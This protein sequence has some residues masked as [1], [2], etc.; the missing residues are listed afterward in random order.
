MRP[1]RGAPAPRDSDATITRRA[2]ALRS[3]G[4]KLAQFPAIFTL[5]GA[6]SLHGDLRKFRCQS[7]DLAL[8]RLDQGHKLLHLRRKPA[9]LRV[10]VIPAAR[11]F[12]PVAP[13]KSPVLRTP[14]LEPEPVLRHDH[15]TQPFV[16]DVRPNSLLVRLAR[17][18]RHFA[19]A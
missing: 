3:D 14:V 18:L 6:A 5:F 7:L 12:G 11:L 15:P 10:A 9:Q 4:G 13:K 1:E 16:H 2:G 8:L 19:E 17:R